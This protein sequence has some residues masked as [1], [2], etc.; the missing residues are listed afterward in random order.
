[1]VW[2]E[3]VPRVWRERVRKYRLIGGRCPSCGNVT[4][5][6]R[7]VCPFCGYEGLEPIELPRRGKVVTFTVIRH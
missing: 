1:M 5:P 7:L 4:Y 3:S 6:H 2:A